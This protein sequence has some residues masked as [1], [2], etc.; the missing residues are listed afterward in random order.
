MP[1]RAGWKRQAA[2]EALLLVAVRGGPQ[3]DQTF[4]RHD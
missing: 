3:I 2:M 1:D 4:F